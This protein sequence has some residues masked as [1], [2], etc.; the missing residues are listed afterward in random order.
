MWIVWS[1][2]GHGGSDQE[3]LEVMDTFQMEEEQRETKH[4]LFGKLRF[5]GVVVFSL[6]VWFA[7]EQ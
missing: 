5:L 2:G 3:F 1:L 6:G 4:G 7:F